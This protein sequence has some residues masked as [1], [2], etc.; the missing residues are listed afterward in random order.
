MKYFV[1][2]NSLA[3]GDYKIDSQHKR[4]FEIFENLLEALGEGKGK[5][6]ILKVFDEL[7]NYAIYHF[8]DE[9]ELMEKINFPYLNIHKKEHQLFTSNVSYLIERYKTE[10]YNVTSETA[11]FLFH[12]LK[13]HIMAE[14][15][16][17]AL[18]LKKDKNILE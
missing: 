11:D 3:I 10:Y 17:I 15:K 5:D 7:S 14:D 4:L 13:N 8:K 18:Y 9:E 16:K 2:D 1:F 12:W 6:V